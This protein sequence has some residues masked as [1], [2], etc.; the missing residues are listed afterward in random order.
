MFVSLRKMSAFSLVAMSLVLATRVPCAAAHIKN[1][2]LAITNP[3]SEARP[4]ANVVLP[5]PE[6]RKV[7]RDFTPGAVIVTTSAASTL[8]EDAA[9]LETAELPSQIDDLDGDGKGDEL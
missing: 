6:I 5:I 2:K 4:A 3:S 8:A 1:I 9:T 7:A